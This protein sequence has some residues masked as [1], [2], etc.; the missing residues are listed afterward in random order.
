MSCEKLKNPEYVVTIAMSGVVILTLGTVIY[1]LWN[2]F[3]AAGV[4]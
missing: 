1:S 4:G 3:S 2:A